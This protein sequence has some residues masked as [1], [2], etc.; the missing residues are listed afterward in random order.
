MEIKQYPSMREVSTQIALPGGTTLSIK[1]VQFMVDGGAPNLGWSARDW[2]T[3]YEA[4][5]GGKVFSGSQLRLKPET[6]SMVD[7]TIKAQQI[8][9]GVYV[10]PEAKAQA[11][12]AASEYEAHAAAVDKMMTLDGKSY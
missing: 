2:S 3:S 8:A 4:R 12:K 6:Q 9:L 11:A 7:E 5:N 1:T 10:S